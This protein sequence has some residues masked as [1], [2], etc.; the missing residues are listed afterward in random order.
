M[1]FE[2]ELSQPLLT[3][4]ELRAK[5]ASVLKS[6]FVEHGNVSI[7][8]T[9][10]YNKLHDDDGLKS[11]FMELCRWLGLKPGKL[12]VRYSQTSHANQP[13][14]QNHVVTIDK[15]FANH[16]Y[17]AGALL[18]FAVLEYYCDRYDVTGIDSEFIEFASI[19]TGLGIWVINGLRPKSKRHAA[20]YHIVRGQ[21]AHKDGISLQRYTAELYAHH[22]ARYAHNNHIMAEEYLPGIS[23]A[24]RYLLP[25]VATEKSSRTLPEPVAITKHRATIRQ[26]WIRYSL[27]AIILA[28]SITFGLYFWYS[29]HPV[30]N[31]RQR[32]DEKALRVMKTSLDACIKKAS[33]QQS[34]YDP[35]D[36]FMTRQVDITKSRC[37]SLRNEYNYA[38]RQY[39]MLYSKN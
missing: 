11:V 30:V 17:I 36:L 34:T 31:V 27:L 19:E 1:K 35:N 26:A 15:Q 3:D 28:S 18:V 7:P 22:V 16:P 2:E 8:T 12:T 38:L 13:L 6:G 25:T 14:Y 23:A 33:D 37:E 32:E 24:H 9:T 20:I 4:E 21:W 29:R 39:E 10:L 5:L